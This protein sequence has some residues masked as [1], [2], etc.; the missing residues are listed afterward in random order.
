MA[1][2]TTPRKRPSKMTSQ[3]LTVYRQEQ[4][5]LKWARRK[6]RTAAWKAGK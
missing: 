3:E 1:E 5:R 6:A 2:T 4:D